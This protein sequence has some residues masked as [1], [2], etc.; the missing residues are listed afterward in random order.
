[1]KTKKLMGQLLLTFIVPIVIMIGTGV[2]IFFAVSGI[3][4]DLEG[5]SR[6]QSQLSRAQTI[7][8]LDE[9]L[10][11]S[12]RNYVFTGDSAWK[13]RYNNSAVQLDDAIA[14][15][16][17][18]AA[19]EKTRAIFERQDEA[20]VNLIE[21][22]TVAFSMVDDGKSEE[23]LAL[24]EG[25]E[26]EKWKTLYKQTVDEFLNSSETGLAAFQAKLE[27]SVQNAAIISVYIIGGTGIIGILLFF[28]AL[29]MSGR[30]SK[31]I[32]IL[33]RQA[34]QIAKG[35]FYVDFSIN[36]TNEIGQL[37]D[38]FKHMANAFQ[39]KAN[40]IDQIA[41]KNLSVTIEKASEKDQLGNSLL[42]MK[43]S[44]NELLGEV[45]LTVS[46]VSTGSDQVSQASQSLSQG[47]TEQ[48][49]SLEEIT[50]SMH[51]IN[52]QSR[53][54]TKNAEEA[55]KIAKEANQSANHGS[56]QMKELIKAMEG[57]TASSDEINKIVKTID[58][59]SFQ[60]N[61]LALNANVEAA[62]AG[63]YG[64]GFAVVA[65]EVRNLANR[66]GQSVLETSGRVE[67]A[68]RNVQRGRELVEKTSKQLEDIVEGSN[69]V[70]QLL[71]EI[72][73][74]SREQT[75]GIEQINEGLEQIDQVTQSNTASA[76]QSAS[77]AVELASQ[78]RQL[79]AMIAQFT[80][81]NGKSRARLLV[82]AKQERRRSEI[83][84]NGG[85]AK[86]VECD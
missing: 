9:V 73:L 80:L 70:A 27:E 47:T 30:I 50:S 54:N 25:N 56:D 8:W 37:A 16:I 42:V 78:A 46:N 44:L 67:E 84:G 76:E 21:L 23:A 14:S 35:D 17:E 49:S 45:T 38:S 71:D 11:Q 72:T 33:T 62:R 10:T 28:F 79:E 20:N 36:E 75:H 5:S 55:N 34:D 66:S 74:A 29:Y 40:I 43:D 61:L 77:S 22:E 7:V 86:I 63:K 83:S 58:D 12:L 13:D 18:H 41:N 51:E 60:I 15:A 26:Y 19:S 65:E 4:A 6:F 82:D 2:F 32:T 24:I 3:K 1:M 48:A 52:S 57:I 68:N 31:P 53:E 39:T 69:K 81:D 64:K 59:I 85:S